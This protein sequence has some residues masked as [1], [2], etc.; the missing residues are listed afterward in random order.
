MSR[1]LIVL[2]ALGF[3]GCSFVPVPPEAAT[4]GFHLTSSRSVRL[5]EPRFDAWDGHLDFR[6]VGYR[7]VGLEIPR[8]THLDVE[9]R[10]RDGYTLRRER[11]Q[12]IFLSV[13]SRISPDMGKYRLHVGALPTGTV[14]I[15]ISVHE[16]PHQPT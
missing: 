16:E 11:I 7:T 2:G 3:A 9:F 14:R 8:S 13:R 4:I 15:E 1:I 10:D 5:Y 12:I 6:G